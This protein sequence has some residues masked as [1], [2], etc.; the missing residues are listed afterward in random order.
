MGG[1]SSGFFLFFLSY[2]ASMLYAHDFSC[3]LICVC[4]HTM[5]HNAILQNSFFAKLQCLFD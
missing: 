4:V 3:V 5:N 2:L 1:Y